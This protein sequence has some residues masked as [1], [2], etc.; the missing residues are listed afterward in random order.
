MAKFPDPSDGKAA[1]SIALPKPRRFSITFQ[2]G[3]PDDDVVGQIQVTESGALIITHSDGS[4]LAYAA[5]VW[6]SVCDI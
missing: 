2:D 1:V 5:G 4:V 6:R 3:H